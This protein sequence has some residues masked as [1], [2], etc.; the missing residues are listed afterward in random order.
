MTEFETKLLALEEKKVSILHNISEDTIRTKEV[1]EGIEESLD[2][3][4][5]KL[6]TLNSVSETI[7][8]NLDG[9]GHAIAELDRTIYDTNGSGEMGDALR[10]LPE[11]AD[12]IGYADNGVELNQIDDTLQEIKKNIRKE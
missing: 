7:E 3:I 12:K 9:I 11:I 10:A 2:I 8:D 4:S 6:G 5:E 1:L